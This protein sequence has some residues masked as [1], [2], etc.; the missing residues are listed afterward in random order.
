MQLSKQGFKEWGSYVK[1]GKNYI[2]VA[3]D[4]TISH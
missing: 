3:L 4:G 2:N 1:K